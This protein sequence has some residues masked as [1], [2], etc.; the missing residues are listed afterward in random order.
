MTG[1]ARAAKTPGVVEVNNASFTTSATADQFND[2]LMR[3][4]GLR[5]RNMAARLALARSLA[6]AS[7]PAP[8]E[9]AERGRTIKGVN[10]FGDDLRLWLGLMLEHRQS[11]DIG[12]EEVQDLTGRHWSR[13]IALLQQ[14]WL[15][16][17]EDFDR[18]ILSLANQCGL[19]ATG[20]GDLGRGSIAEVSLRPGAVVLPLGEVGTDVVTREPVTWHL[21]APGAA[22]HM[23][24]LG[25]VGSG[26]TRTAM[27]LI[28]Q[29]R[30]Q[31]NAPVI[32]FDMAKGDIASNTDL[33]AALGAT[34]VN[35]LDSPIPL[36][37]LN[38]PEGELKQAA[39]RFRESFRRVPANRIGDA[40]GDVLREA[41]EAAFAGG[42][43]IRLRDVYE[44]LQEAY[45]K[46]R[47]RKGDIVTATFKDMVTWE[48][49]A[50]QLSPA[51][52][53]SR[54]W[55][56]DLHKAPETVKRLVCFLLFD[57]AYT[58]LGQCPDTP[59]DDSGNRALRLV[60]GIDE[61]RLVLGYE[62]HS[63]IALVRESRSKGGVLVFMSQSPDDFD[64]KTENFFEN[65]GL[66]LCFKTAARSSALNQL[67]GE[68]VDLNSLKS[69]VCVSR[70]PD[71]GLMFV[72]A[73]QPS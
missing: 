62:H 44:R 38:A 9:G 71:R 52:F 66:A 35:P 8:L 59:V 28:R 23:A 49:F 3:K 69:G 2:E 56:I 39:M 72:Q 26:K 41:A 27:F 13:G 57:A 55:I 61:A 11:E 53:F 70:L 48:L 29:I 16:A 10:L 63:L 18:F 31:S 40:Q 33:V 37:V 73:W 15:E 64:Q 58:Y 45:A 14:D 17:G 46:R 12:L 68:N 36:D 65:V 4:L 6:L 60:I 42:E 21:N 43:A 19:P 50:P 24:V 7:D 30:G 51:E 22:P 20:R 47:V 25:A 67:L 1:P 5:N 54:S 34:V 32:L